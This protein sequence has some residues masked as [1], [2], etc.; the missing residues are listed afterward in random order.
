VTGLSNPNYVIASSGN[1]NGILTI[2]P[3]T[4]TY[5]AN[6]ASRTYGAANP[7]L[8]GTVTGFV[9][10]DALASVTSGT[11]ALLIHPK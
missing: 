3:A 9:N 7:A 5:T 6:A 4:L 2:N 11:L 8:S 1:T 10:G